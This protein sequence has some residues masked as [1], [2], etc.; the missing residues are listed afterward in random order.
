MSS[1]RPNPGVALEHPVH[2][3]PIRDGQGPLWDRQWEDYLYPLAETGGEEVLHNRLGL[4][5]PDDLEMAE[6]ALSA[7]RQLQLA[8]DPSLVPRTFTVAHWQAIHR[9]LFRDLYDWAGQF[10]TVD[11]ARPI[12]PQ[13]AVPFVDAD[14]LHT[15]GAELM[16]W[17]R[18]EHMFAG[19]PRAGVVSGVTIALATANV[20][21][22]FREGNGRTQRVL[23]EHLAE[24]AGYRLDWSRIPTRLEHAAQM[25]AYYDQPHYLADVLDTAL[26]RQ[27]EART[28]DTAITGDDAA[29]PAVSVAS[30]WLTSRA[31]A[32]VL[33][34]ARA[35]E[36]T[37][38]ADANSATTRPM[39]H[40]V[41]S[42][43]TPSHGY[44]D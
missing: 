39:Q 7:G 19:R 11:I 4:R 2:V 29:V 23:A 38:A 31:A 30:P 1:P 5:D 21:H 17:L 42:A 37:A 33:T 22:P 36:H 20:I 12:G 14:E 18:D 24:A 9:H 28:A 35:A 10:R 44:G 41:I 40:G 32:D 25:M 34:T 8:R 43:P 15:K 6:R 16:G 26:T 27:P 13:Q 3:A